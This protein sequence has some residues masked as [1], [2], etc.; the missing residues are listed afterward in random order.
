LRCVG[1][2]READKISAEQQQNDQG[3]SHGSA[4]VIHSASMIAE[5]IGRVIPLLSVILGFVH[6]VCNVRR[7]P[8]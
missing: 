8:A 1:V 3:D 4:H 6:C 5:S 7:P 2:V